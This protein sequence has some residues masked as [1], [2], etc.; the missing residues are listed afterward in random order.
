M[1]ASVDTSVSFDTKN[2]R[3]EGGRAATGDQTIRAVRQGRSR[4]T[5]SLT[6]PHSRTTLGQSAPSRLGHHKSKLRDIAGSEKPKWRACL[7]PGHNHMILTTKGNRICRAG[8]QQIETVDPI[9]GAAT[10]IGKASW[11]SEEMA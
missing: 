2:G 1:R 8:H 9:Y 11:V 7:A 10:G 5:S 3:D 4:S 6:T